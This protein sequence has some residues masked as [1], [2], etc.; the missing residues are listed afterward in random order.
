MKLS[1][2]DP[3][4]QTLV[5]RIQNGDLD[6]QPDFQRGEV[7]SEA[8]KRRLIDTILRDW[9]VP[10]LHTVETEGGKSEILDGQQ[11]L[12]AIRD[13][14]AGDLFVDGMVEP[15]DP[16]ITAINGAS[17]ANLPP[18]LRRRFDKFSIRVLRITDYK[19][20]EPP[21]LFYRLNQPTGFRQSGS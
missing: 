7:W 1:A 2:S 9:H 15:L 19:P 4:I 10:P 20:E 21:E 16:E 14:V 12:A 8:K 17:Y 18:N 3:D 11:R 6:L 13:F 5:S